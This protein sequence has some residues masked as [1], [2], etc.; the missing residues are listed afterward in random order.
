[1]TLTSNLLVRE[2]KSAWF[3]SFVRAVLLGLCV[4][5]HVLAVNFSWT[6][7]QFNNKD[8]NVLANSTCISN[9]FRDKNTE[10]KTAGNADCRS[11]IC[12]GHNKIDAFLKVS[13]AFN[14]SQVLM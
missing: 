8:M 1:M 7:F 5:F 9:E 10:C 6:D 3:R 13:D 2:E 14:T 12:D 11:E 4:L